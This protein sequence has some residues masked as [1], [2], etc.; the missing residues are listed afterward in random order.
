MFLRLALGRILPLVPIIRLTL[1][2][3]KAHT[4]YLMQIAAE[5]VL[6]F[7]SSK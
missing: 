1:I 6:M 7:P 5:L 2:D 3:I 4:I